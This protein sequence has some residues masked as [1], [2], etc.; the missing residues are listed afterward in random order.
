MTNFICYILKVCEWNFVSRLFGIDEESSREWWSTRNP[1]HVES[2]P[3]FFLS[4][5]NSFLASK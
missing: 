1:S 4:K 3:V 2:L 5:I